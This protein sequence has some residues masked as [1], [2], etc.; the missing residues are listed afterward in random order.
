MSNFLSIVKSCPLFLELYDDEVM[1]IVE[2]CH[3]TSLEKNE[4]IFREGDKGDELY[5]IMSGSVHVEKNKVNLATLKKGDL[6]GELVLIND[7]IRSADIICDNFT[8]LL[9]MNYSDIFGLYNTEPKIFSIIMLNLTRL[10]TK[11]LKN[12]SNTIKELNMR[13]QLLENETKNVA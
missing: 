2:K 11:R 1:K 7:N 12:S 8:D 9:I 3:V 13:I 10:L 4:F 6:F 5:I